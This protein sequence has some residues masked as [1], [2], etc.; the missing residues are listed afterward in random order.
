M[1]RRLTGTLLVA[2]IFALP[3]AGEA[4]SSKRIAE[5][6][7][8][9]DAEIIRGFFRIALG[10]ELRLRGRTDRIRKYDGPIRVYVDNRGQPDRR[11][12]VAEVIA[13]IRSRV[14]N[15]DIAITEKRDDANFVVTLVRDRDLAR[16][17]HAFFGRHARRIQASLQPQ[18]LSGFRKDASYRIVRSAVILV[19]DAGDFIFRDCAYEEILQALGPINDDPSVPWTMFNDDV[20]LGYFGLYDQYLL[21]ILYHPRIRPGMTRKEIEP[22]L[23]Q[24]LPEVRAWVARVNGLPHP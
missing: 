18:C 13:D 16:T 12:Q 17:I 24:I 7:S 5:R 4:A 8:F 1:V 3:L 11:N 23:R 15:L 10:A 14:A 19:V 6:K 22:L 9:T 20:Q 21:N 2:A